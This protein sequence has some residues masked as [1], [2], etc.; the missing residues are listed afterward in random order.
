MGIR[1]TSRESLVS[2]ALTLA[3]LKPKQVRFVI[4]DGSTAEGEERRYSD[5]D[6]IAVRKGF[7]KRRASVEDLFGVFDRRIFSGWL[8]SDDSFSA[9]L[10]ILDN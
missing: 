4:L 3:K 9:F 8:V 5:Y 1:A 6:I 10:R 2:Y 7:S